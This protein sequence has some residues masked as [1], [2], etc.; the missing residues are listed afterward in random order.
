M[1][2][3]NEFIPPNAMIEIFLKIR[4]VFVKYMN[5]TLYFLIYTIINFFLFCASLVHHFNR[6]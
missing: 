5:K 3:A 4:I 1:Q 6:R 2:L